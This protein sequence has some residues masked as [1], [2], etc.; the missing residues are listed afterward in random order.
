MGSCLLYAGGFT[1]S[2]EAGMAFLDWP[3]SN[4]SINPDGWTEIRDMRAE[5][6]HR[7]LGMA[8]G[9]LGIILVYWTWL[10]EGREWVRKLARITL[11]IIILQGVLGGARVRFDKLNIFVEN[12][13]IA[14]TFAILHAVG[15]QIVICLL[16]AIAVACSKKWFVDK[17]LPNNSVSKSLQTC[18]VITCIIIFL[19]I[20][21]GAIMRHGEAGL[22]IFTFP[23]STAEGTWIPT[24]WNWAIIINFSHRVGA[25]IC[26]VSILIFVSKIWFNKESSQQLSKYTIPLVIFLFL[27]ILIGSLV[28]VTRLNEHAATI[29]LLIGA[30]LL[31][32]CWMLTFLTFRVND[33]SK[34]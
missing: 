2:I 12:N 14:T 16:V 30:F 19:Q 13:F 4:G 21:I 22:A 24:F 18:G 26:F 1:T 9:L 15:A 32:S 27:Q 29:H 7:L 11:L 25:I 17:A 31:A 34:Q 8:V 6:S 28:V 10:K 5:H 23:Y 3:L 20:L 33:L